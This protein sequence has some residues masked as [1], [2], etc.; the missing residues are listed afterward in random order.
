[1]NE[2]PKISWTIIKEFEE[3][4]ILVEVSMSDGYR[5]RYNVRVGR[6]GERGT[7]PFLQ[8]RVEGQGKVRVI[9]VSETVAKLLYAAQEFV[10]GR[11]QEHEDK[12][13]AE[14]IE[15]ESRQVER[16]GKKRRP[17]GYKHHGRQN[18]G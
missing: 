14:R 17:S 1:M 6:R 16:E 10:E 18:A 3:N 2:R 4:G 13:I 5:P 12:F 9:D 8:L 11:V 15:R 7:I